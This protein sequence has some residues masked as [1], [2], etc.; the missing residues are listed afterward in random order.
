MYNNRVRITFDRAKRAQTLRVR[1][2][3]FKDAKH[4][5]AG[6]TLDR[7]DDREDYGEVRMLTVGYLAGRMVM[8]CGRRAAKPGASSR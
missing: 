5:F 7:Q 6:R 4:V 1:G 8:S 3:D 2:I